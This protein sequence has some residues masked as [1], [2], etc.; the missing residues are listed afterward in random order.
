MGRFK[1]EVIRYNC[2]SSHHL[3]YFIAVIPKLAVREF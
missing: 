2:S 1:D 3:H